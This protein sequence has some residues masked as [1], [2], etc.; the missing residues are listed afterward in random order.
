[1]SWQELIGA[2]YV[3]VNSLVSRPIGSTLTKEKL[4][5]L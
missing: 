2:R 5:S 4:V 3:L 1:M